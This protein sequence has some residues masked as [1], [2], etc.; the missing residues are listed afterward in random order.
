MEDFLMGYFQKKSKKW[1]ATRVFGLFLTT[2]A[3]PLFMQSTTQLVIAADGAFDINFYE[4]PSFANLSKSLDL[5][6][7]ELK[8]FKHQDIEFSTPDKKSAYSTGHAM[9]RFYETLTGEF[10]DFSAFNGILE[11]MKGHNAADLPQIINFFIDS[12][13]VNFH[14]L[15][16]EY[17]RSGITDLNKQDVLKYALSVKMSYDIGKALLCFWSVIDGIQNEQD[18]S[19]AKAQIL[20]DERK[21]EI[22]VKYD[23]KVAELNLELS[24][25]IEPLIADK[26]NTARA[27]AAAESR[28]KEI[29]RDI[30]TQELGRKREIDAETAR[31][32]AEKQKIIADTNL[33]PTN[34]KKAMAQYGGYNLKS[35]VPLV[36]HREDSTVFQSIESKIT[37]EMI[38]QS[39]RLLLG[40]L[41]QKEVEPRKSII[42][43]LVPATDDHKFYNLFGLLDVDTESLN[44]LV[45]TIKIAERNRQ[46]E[47]ERRAAEQQKVLQALNSGIQQIVIEEK[48][49][50]AGKFAAKKKKKEG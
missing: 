44:N 42:D 33:I 23:A 20:S 3:I 16:S 6:A 1:T 15:N 32:E 34:Y 10:V 48:T 19:I 31:L 37:P 12:I 26:K 36:S 22:Q 47:Q 11:K 40:A 8:K 14:R 29:N 45:T 46:I 41:L 39:E 27:I 49:T 21:Q 13:E 28:K 4:H 35:Y 43:F 5:A 38:E 7:A 25:Q 30:A 50:P 2:A 18:V 24:T 17:N 9:R